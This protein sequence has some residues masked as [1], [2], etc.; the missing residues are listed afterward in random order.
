LEE[1]TLA[2]V[3]SRVFI[4]SS[5]ET[6]PYVNAVHDRLSHHAEVTPWSAAFGENEY[7]MESLE[8]Q[9][10]SN[11]FAVFIFSPDDIANIRG[12]NYFV[13]RDNTLFEMGLFWGRLRR[14]RVFNIIPQSIPLNN[15]EDNI[16]GYH[17]PTD[18][19]G[20][21]VLT[22]DSR[23]DGN[24]IAAVDRACGRIIEK[25]N[26]LGPFSDPLKSLDEAHSQAD[27]DYNLIRFYRKFSKGLLNNSYNKFENLAD[28][29]RSAFAPPAGY[30][31]DGIGVWQA[32]GSDGLQHLAGNET[33]DE[34]F[35]NF[36]VN[37]NRSEDDKISIVD[38]YLKSEEQV[39]EKNQIRYD[40]TYVICY[41]IVK[42]LVLQ[43]ALTG[44]R[45]LNDDDWNQVFVVNYDLIQGINYL[46]RGETNGS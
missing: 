41:P 18:L 14:G 26:N 16:E 40:K 11:D 43:V 22:Y 21:T 37:Q 46:F 31:V 12:K 7:T 27:L 6:I 36:N 44:R 34:D 45:E 39:Y 3:K 35:Y 30:S 5:R 23:N 20:I 15:V 38:S 17:L 13:T 25:T 33:L 24:Y 42:K 9:L 2:E 32:L 19:N 10:D 29:L 4:G 1:L 8:K 28:S